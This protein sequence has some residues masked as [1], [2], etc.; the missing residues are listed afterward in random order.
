VRRILKA[1]EEHLGDSAEIEVLKVL[2][3]F[4][5]PADRKAVLAVLSQPPIPDL[6][7]RLCELGPHALRPVIERLRDLKLMS[8][9]SR[10]RPEILDTH[11]LVREYFASRLRQSAPAAWREGNSRLYEHL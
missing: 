4:D 9:E 3:L 5:G 6:T 8:P 1:F 10:H 2:S 7:S 11:P